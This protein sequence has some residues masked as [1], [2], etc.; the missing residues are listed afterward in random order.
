MQEAALRVPG[1]LD[2]QPQDARGQRRDDDGARPALG[3]PRSGHGRHGAGGDDPVE[4]RPVG[5]APRAVA[6]DDGRVV[7]GL[8]EAGAGR[9]GDVRVDVHG[10]D[11][12][13]AQAVGEQGRVVPGP[14]ADLQRGVAVPYVE[15]VQH[16]RHEG[17]LAGGGDQFAAAQQGAQRPVLV[18]AVQPAPPRLRCGVVAPQPFVPAV[19]ADVVVGDEQVPGHVREGRPPGRVG[20][21]ALGVEPGHEPPP[22]PAGGL[23]E[24]V[25][26]RRIPGRVLPLPRDTFTH[27]S[28]ITPS[29]SPRRTRRTGKPAEDRWKTGGSPGNTRAGRDGAE[30]GHRRKAGS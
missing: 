5:A 20:Q 2:A 15:G 3:E 21:R 1:V 4:G 27:M 6:G 26:L 16:V 23:G 17:R 14:R 29:V 30:A 13:V 11:A 9:V 18:G 12:R 22:R 8:V 7:A 19:G 10:R 28:T 25:V 24:R